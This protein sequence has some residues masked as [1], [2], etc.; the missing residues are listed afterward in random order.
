MAR[1]DTRVTVMSPPVLR[2]M[3][4]VVAGLGVGFGLVLFA[5]VSFGGRPVLSTI[6]IVALPVVFWIYLVAGLIAWWRRPRNGLGPLLVWAGVAVWVIGAGNTTVPAFR[7]I[8][9]VLATLSVA[10]IT[11][12]L[13]A[14]PAGRLTS[15]VDRAIVAG[16]YVVAVVLQAPRY[17]FVP[18][19]TSPSLA[20]ADLPELAGSLSTV[21]VVVG[22]TL[23]A[24]A[25]VVLLVRV[26]RAGPLHRRTLGPVYAYGIF[27]VLF[28]PLIALAFDTWR[29]DQAL[30]RAGIQIAA[31]SLVPVVVLVAFLLGGF[32][33]TAE[34]E[35]LGAWLGESMATR[36][37]I[38]DALATALG[39]P[40]LRV[41]YW[42]GELDAWVAPD[43]ARVVL[44][45]PP[46]GRARREI[47]LDGLPVAAI[48]YDAGMLPDPG[49]VRRATNLVALALEREGLDAELRASRQAVVESRERLLSAAD[50]ER[51]RISRVLHDGLQAR[52]VLIGVEAQRLAVAPAAE[53]SARA[54]DL[55][56]DVDQA[57]E[58][59]RAF[60]HDLVPPALTELGLA[61]AIE[62][63]VHDM[64]MPTRLDAEV[65]D[66]LGETV[67]TTAYF[68]VA[69]ALTNVVKHA[70]ASSCAV[71]LRSDDGSLT[72]TVTDDGTGRADPRLGSG[73]AG[74]SDRAAAVGGQS[75]VETPP[76]G[77]TTIW[78]QLP[79]G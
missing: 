12:L 30:I 27:V 53:I 35:E 11:H 29:P 20:V 48:E 50:A 44:A 79:C 78:A 74:I 21:Q 40:T 26:A 43:G 45:A 65:T 14:F 28:V 3:L 25:A 62:E 34:L 22:N 66:R 18:E 77:G 54:N 47:L 8:G 13:L 2:G 49:E 9:T 32:G 63:L 23:T 37:S 16:A 24:A 15:R 19:A 33:R 68:I 70:G 6:L 71:S 7:L 55:R 4:V 73:L 67:E 69:E 38:R 59:L 36:R 76:E 31:I 75:R 41:S 39:D 64:P 1:S 61:G 17:L 52:L 42:S 57:A 72:L 51:R 5:T 46:P 60:V 56:A 58:E 10:A